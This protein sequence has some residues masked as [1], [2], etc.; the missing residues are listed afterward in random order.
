MIMRSL[1]ISF[2]GLEGTDFSVLKVATNLLTTRDGLQIVLHENN[3]LDSNIF[4][5][6]IDK[7]AGKQ[8][9]KNF[10]YGKNHTLLVICENSLNDQRHYVLRKPVRVQTLRDAIFDIYNELFNKHNKN[11]ADNTSPKI[12]TSATATSSA[13]TPAPQTVVS[14][15]SLK[16]NDILFFNLLELTQ[17][18]QCAQLFCSPFP[19]LFINAPKK[20]VATSSSRDILRKIT[21][22]Q[23][24]KLNNTKL[25]DSDFEV[26]SRGQLMMPLEHLLWSSALYGSN[27][28]LMKE[29]T[30]DT[31]LQLKAWPN[32]SR[33][34]FEPEHMKL[35][36]LLSTMPMSVKQ[37]H[38]RTQLALP[39]IIGFF[40]AIHATGLTVIRQAAQTEKKVENKP[41]SSIK[42]GLLNKI[43]QR[44]KISVT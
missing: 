27:G 18:Q 16:S 8:A 30:E 42:Q 41:V 17:Q 5:V 3:F 26:L 11:V 15:S 6:D 38:T 31:M 35:T 25:L 9:Y 39:V 37:V 43:A 36:S 21:R 14:N 29:L 40:N 28:I 22:N 34:E 2:V 44:L 7:E 10:E 19:P 33:L 23:N 4:I 20:L 12:V 1:A 24:N 32:F 13:V